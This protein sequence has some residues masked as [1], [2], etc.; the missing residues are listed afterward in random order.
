MNK[1][2]TEKDFQTVIEDIFVTDGIIEW[3]E[4]KEAIEKSFELAKRMA[5]DFSQTTYKDHIYGLMNA[6]WNQTHHPERTMDE[7]FEL[8]QQQNNG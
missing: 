3:D 4:K 6:S 8:Y 5:I 7:L 1:P 2:I